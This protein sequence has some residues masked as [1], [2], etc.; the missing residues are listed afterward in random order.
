MVDGVA[1]GGLVGIGQAAGAEEY[2]A[3]VADHHDERVRQVGTQQLP[4]DGAS[5]GAAGLAVVIGAEGVLARAEDVGVA[6]VAGVKVVLAQLLQA[7][8]HLLLAVHRIGEGQELAPFLLVEALGGG[9]DGSVGIVKHGCKDTH[10]SRPDKN[11]F[12]HHADF[13]YFCSR[14]TITPTQ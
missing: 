13:S 14:Y 3:E 6:M 1:G 12:C 5:A 11:I 8:F 4:V 9:A 10:I 2:A 7:G